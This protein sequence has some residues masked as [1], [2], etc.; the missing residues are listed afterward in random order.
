MPLRPT[1]A[2][3]R[4]AVTGSIPVAAGS[5]RPPGWSFASPPQRLGGS[6]LAGPRCRSWISPWRRPRDA[7]RSA[8]GRADGE[9][10]RSVTGSDHRRVRTQLASKFHVVGYDPPNEA[11]ASAETLQRSR[12]RRV[13]LLASVGRQALGDSRAA[14]SY[15]FDTLCMRMRRAPIY[16][17]RLAQYAKNV[18]FAR[19]IGS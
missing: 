2:A 12:A 18:H 11:D 3:Q 14:L 9:R 8:F 5:L 4:P 10:R 7:R 6:T 1:C 17:I 19:T 16:D 15:S 13:Q